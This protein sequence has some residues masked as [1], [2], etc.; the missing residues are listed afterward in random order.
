MTKDDLL[1]LKEGDLVIITKEFDSD[2]DYKI[3]EE[4]IYTSS[5][6]GSGIEDN[7]FTRFDFIRNREGSPAGYVVSHFA[8]HIHDYIEK[9]STIRDNKINEILK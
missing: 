2:F 7:G 3:G 6:K 5:F 9:K 1:K 4:L 8:V